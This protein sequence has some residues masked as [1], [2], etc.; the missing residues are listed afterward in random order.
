MKYLNFILICILA[1]GLF[2]C[3]SAAQKGALSRAYSNYESGDYEDVLELTA[4]A[5]SYQEPSPEMKAEILFL[6]AMALEKLGKNKEAIGLFRYLAE[7]HGST[8][9]G[10]MAKE[11]I[12]GK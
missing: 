11:R 6:K 9:Y 7:N 12:K 2:G 8:Q 1:F 10:F 3:A 5:E 4:R